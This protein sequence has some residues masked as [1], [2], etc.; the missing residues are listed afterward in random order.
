MHMLALPDDIQRACMRWEFSVWETCGGFIVTASHMTAEHKIKEL[1]RPGGLKYIF[2]KD[3]AMV[4]YSNT[5]HI[6]GDWATQIKERAHPK[7]KGKGVQM[8]K[9]ERKS[10][11]VE[12]DTNV[13]R[14]RLVQI[15]IS[16]IY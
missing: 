12:Y 2:K 5:P 1:K 16:P 9:D 11:M 14:T 10:A 7:N 3:S 8:L 13:C 15:Q 6:T 4:R